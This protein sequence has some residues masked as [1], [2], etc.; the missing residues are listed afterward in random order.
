MINNFTRKELLPVALI[1]FAFIIGLVLYPELPEQI[2]SH[3]NARGE[4]DAWSGKTFGV[5]FLPAIA[6]GVYLLMTFLP[7]IDPLKK[8]YARFALPYYWLRT[9]MVLFLV[10]LYLYS[11][12]M[13]L[14][15]EFNI[16]YFILPAFSILFISIG[17]V[18]PKV[19]KNYFVGIRTPWT[20]HS[21]EVWDKTHRFGGKLFVVAGLVALVGLVFPN[22]SFSIFIAAVLAAALLSLVY[23]YFA[24]RKIKESNN[25]SMA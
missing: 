17:L 19:K 1:V 10:L 21:E 6:L 15:T 7:L 14:G 8:N 13:A 24:Y 2:P 5:L 20:L 18:L 16:N 3:W 25:N 4:V 12:G 9:I 11:L 22:L 23:S